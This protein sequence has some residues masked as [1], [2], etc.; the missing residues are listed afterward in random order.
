MT[1]LLKTRALS[2]FFCLCLHAI[3]IH[4][5]FT[6]TSLPAVRQL[7]SCFSRTMDLFPK[8]GCQNLSTHLSF[9]QPSPAVGSFLLH[10]KGATLSFLLSFTDQKWRGRVKAPSRAGSAKIGATVTGGSG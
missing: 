4:H 8:A 10:Q 6:H 2:I 7:T 9:C 5:Q 1:C 3:H